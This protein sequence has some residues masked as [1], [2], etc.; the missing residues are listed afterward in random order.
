MR[1]ELFHDVLA[2]PILEWRRG[3][4]QRRARRRWA[5]IGAALVALV[6]VFAGLGIWALIEQGHAQT[7][8]EQLHV[9]NASLR[10]TN[11][12][13]RARRHALEIEVANA[14]GHGPALKALLATNQDLKRQVVA[15]DDERGQLESEN[16][17]LEAQNKELA[18]S[19][20][21]LN[22]ENTELAATINRLH[23]NAN[24]MTT[25]LFV[26]EDTEATLGSDASVLKA[27]RKDFAREHTAITRENR[28]LTRTAGELGFHLRH[29]FTPPVTSG[30]PTK[31][32]KLAVAAQ[33]PIPPPVAAFDR[34][35][36]KVA[37][38][39]Q[40][41]AN[42]R[43]RQQQ[44]GR[45][46][47]ENRLLL[48]QRGTLRAE[49]VELGAARARLQVRERR[50]DQSRVSARVEH[51]GLQ[52][53][54]R[55]AEIAF[56]RKD[57]QVVQVQKAI[58]A[59]RAK[60]DSRVDGIIRLQQDIAG[61]QHDNQLLVGFLRSVTK[62]LVRAAEAPSQDA[63]VAGLLAVE[64]FRVSP[65]TPDDAAYPGP[66]NAL[67][68]SLNR[69]DPAAAAALI[70]PKA[71]SAG[72]IGTTHSKLLK[73]QICRHVSGAIPSVTWTQ[74]VHVAEARYPSS[75]LDEPCG[76]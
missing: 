13:L 36:K 34:L 63:G 65:D 23:R 55:L 62:E 49:N 3:Y 37:A 8:A 35:S 2:E 51:T 75:P 10:A 24:S 56:R 57:H 54:A 30:A 69:L 71:S 11:R 72:K 18:T 66:Y 32:H 7:R 20:S 64:A 43:S 12:G 76:K 33:S 61:A 42:L 38:L 50:L 53:R 27:E 67:W 48:Q 28:R 4:E 9:I 40:E 26:D 74:Y 19:V 6:A 45:L 59:L 22:S 46:R 70:A 41:L 68:L 1:Y 47:S 58:R 14:Q 60:K 31:R 52:A 21:R 17:S 73:Q 39:Q 25:K 16:A 29:A 44:A 15:L 5:T